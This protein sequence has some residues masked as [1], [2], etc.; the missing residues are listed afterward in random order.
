MKFKKMNYIVSKEY[1]NEVKSVRNKFFNKE[2]ST[3]NKNTK[4]F[5]LDFLKN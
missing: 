2:S 1:Q 5:L 3:T 4:K